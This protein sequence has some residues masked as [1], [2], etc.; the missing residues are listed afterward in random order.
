MV[1]ARGHSCPNPPQAPVEQPG[2]PQA[3]SVRARLPQF[4]ATSA[5]AILGRSL[6]GKLALRYASDYPSG[7]NQ[8]WWV[9]AAPAPEPH[10]GSGWQMLLPARALPPEFDSGTDAPA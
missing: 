10:V 2:I 7:L 5:D 6:A 3:P 4:L 9:D 1:N 8:A